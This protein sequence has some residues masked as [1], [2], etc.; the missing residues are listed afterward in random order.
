MYEILT[1]QLGGYAN[2]VGSHFW[3]LQVGGGRDV[4]REICDAP[5]LLACR[6]G[7]FFPSSSPPRG[8]LPAPCAVVIA[9]NTPDIASQPALPPMAVRRRVGIAPWGGGCS[10]RTPQPSPGVSRDVGPSPT[11]P[12]AASR[13]PR[14]ERA[15]R[16][17]RR[18]RVCLPHARLICTPAAYVPRSPSRLLSDAHP[19]PQRPLGN[20][21]V[22]TWSRAFCHV[23]VQ[24]GRY[25]PRVPVL[26]SAQAP[27][28]SLDRS[29][30]HGVPPFSARLLHSADCT[31]L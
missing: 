1:L 31:I 22:A 12:P 15:P 10:T 21:D 9:R 24:F 7:E 5:T 2:Y 18:R 6:G 16:S 29:F 13:P 17:P 11:L 14:R 26:S 23:P 27:Q 30:K 19:L 25:R 8:R 20:A 28:T 3:N 4:R